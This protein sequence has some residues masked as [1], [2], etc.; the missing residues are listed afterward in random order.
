MPELYKRPFAPE[1]TLTEDEENTQLVNTTPPKNP[2][3]ETWKKR[4]G[5]LRSHSQKQINELTSRLAALETQLKASTKDNFQLPS[6]P[7]EVEAWTKRYPQVAAVIETLAIQKY[8]SLNESVEDRLKLLT[9]RESENARN[10]ALIELKKIHSDFDD[11]QNN[12]DFHD[13]LATKSI[14]TQDTIYKND[15]DYQAAAETIS[16]FKLETNFGRGKPNRRAEAKDS[17]REV[18]ASRTRSPSSSLEPIFKESEIMAM[19]GKEFEANA[20][21]IEKAQREGRIEMDITN[22]REAARG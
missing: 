5:D 16:L 2:E 6:T 19:N 15:T 20:E 12:S 22:S 4:Y 3:D 11:I 10:T 21:A 14:R 1:E 9:E 13:W 17:A 18:A 7:E 8:K